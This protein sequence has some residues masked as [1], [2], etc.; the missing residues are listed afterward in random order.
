[1][2][3]VWNQ[4]ANWDKNILLPKRVI[5]ERI[6]WVS[7]F[8]GPKRRNLYACPILC[9]KKERDTFSHFWRTDQFQT[10][11]AVFFPEQKQHSFTF[12]KMANK[13][14]LAAGDSQTCVKESLTHKT[15]VSCYTNI[16]LHLSHVFTRKKKKHSARTLRRKSS[17]L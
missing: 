11:T 1:M 10:V 16:I 8:E 2:N 9:R 4:Q 15:H 13:S 7:T 12:S 17:L 6:F 5:E 3:L 14:L